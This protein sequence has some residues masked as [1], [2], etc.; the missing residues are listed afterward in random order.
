V[1]FAGLATVALALSSQGRAQKDEKS[2]PAKAPAAKASAT[3][4]YYGTSACVDCHTKGMTNPVL[5]RCTEVLIWEKEDKHKDAYKV[6]LGERSKRM[7]EL[8]SLNPATDRRCVSCHGVHIDDAK[9]KEESLKVGFKVEDGVSCVAC[10][11]AYL[12][13]VEMH[14]SVIR[15]PQWRALSREEK[16]QKFGMTDL[17]DPAKRTR[18]CASCHIG[19]AAEGKVVTH[20]MY[21][22]GHPPLPGFEP[23]LFSD[24]MPR[25]WE[26]LREKKPEAQKLLNFDPS[27]LEKTEL[28]VVGGA[29]ALREALDV[30]ASQA[31]TAAD[32]KDPATRLLDWAQFDCYACHHDLRSPSWRQQRGYSGPPGR[33]AM[34]EWP[35]ALARVA[36]RSVGEEARL[37]ENLNALATAFVARPFGRPSDIAATA[38]N[39][40]G[41]LNDLTAKLSAK[42]YD[43]A[44][45]RDLLRQLCTL[46][47]NDL[48]DYD[49]ARQL[50]WAIREIYGEIEPKPAGNAKIQELLGTLDRELRLALPSGSKQSILEEL[51]VTL[52]RMGDYDPYRF[53]AVLEQLSA[54]LAP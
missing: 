5:C 44:A 54:L 25:H 21:A 47:P 24:A 38:S 49:S 51:P 29:V 30:V 13:W 27:K 10:H 34:R 32:G 18:M 33:P 15:R 36:A 52:Q 35:T 3:P 41:W 2:G 6:L 17:W 8:L 40:T 48:P 46:R 7:G 31:R 42:K 11:G 45:A 12:E 37:D 16:E 22:A 28:V 1:G 53:K 39:F 23:A 20:A 26:Y 14:G 9:L 50:A 4:I 43:Q 19:N